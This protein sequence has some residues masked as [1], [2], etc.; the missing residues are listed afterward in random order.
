MFHRIVNLVRKELLQFR[1]DWLMTLFILTLPVLQLMLLA[2]STGSRI[3]GL[4]VA[5]LDLDRSAPSRRLIATLDTRRELNVC[6]LPHTLAETNA[7]LDRGEAA[8]SIVIPPGFASELATFGERA[9]VMLVGDAA[10]SVVGRIALAAAQ[11]AVAS[12]SR[13]LAREAGIL[14]ASSAKVVELRTAIHFNPAL[15]LRFFA[16]SAQVGF[17]VYQVTLVVASVG[18]ARERE[19]GTLEQLMV[20]PLRRVE[21][22]IGKAIPALVI[23]MLN[24]AILLTVA[25]FGFGLPMRGSFPLLFGLTLLFV[26]VEICYGVLISTLA[27]TQQQAVLFVFVLAMVD[28]AFSGYL[29]RVKNLPTGLQAVAAIVPFRHYLDIIR[30]VML[31]GAGWETLWPHAVAMA[32]MG[33]LVALVAVRNSSRRLD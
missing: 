23:G 8:L 21:L 5:A 12:F 32:M 31:K 14:T 29:V 18:L 7:L 27:R 17:I 4:C 20:M 22:I 13:D 26:T 19:L 10:N 30:G 3:S 1:R 11:E 15:N 9:T 6:Y 25:I 2:Q 33:A 24:F 16:I 28:M